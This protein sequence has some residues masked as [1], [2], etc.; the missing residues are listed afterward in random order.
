[1]AL[2]QEEETKYNATAGANTS[3]RDK[4]VLMA[5]ITPK[6]DFGLLRPR[7]AEKQRLLLATANIGTRGA[8]LADSGHGTHSI[9]L[10]SDE[11]S[12]KTSITHNSD[13]AL[14]SEDSISDTDESVGA[15]VHGGLGDPMQNTINRAVPGPRPTLGL[16]RGGNSDWYLPDP[17]TG[18]RTPTS[19]V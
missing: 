15:S 1:M 4:E 6:Q 8:I 18:A 10:L 3:G 5:M 9:S 11:E 19:H 13:D 12:K 14:G 16:H 2:E 17:K 7:N